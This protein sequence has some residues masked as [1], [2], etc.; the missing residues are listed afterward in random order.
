MKKL[1]PKICILL[2]FIEVIARLLSPVEWYGEIESLAKDNPV[3]YI[4]IGSSRVG[5]SINPSLF[6]QTVGSGDNQGITVNLAKGYTTLVE[7]LFGILRIADATPGKLKGTVVFLEAPQGDIAVGNWQDGWLHQE[8][9]E[10]LATTMR[11]HDLGAFWL[12]SNADVTSKLMVTSSMLSA[13]PKLK[14]RWRTVFSGDNFLPKNSSKLAKGP[15]WLA[16]EV[17]TDDD[18]IKNARNLALADADRRID[19][20]RPLSADFWDKSVLKSLNAQVT[21]AGGRLVLFRMP[22]SSI[23]ARIGSTEVGRKNDELVCNALASNGI[24]ILEPNMM[25]TDADF[26]DLWHLRGSRNAEYTQRVAQAYLDMK[27]N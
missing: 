18:G 24:P 16:A 13:I 17:R 15:L 22:I 20:L 9:P 5:C 8:Y 27:R 11:T 2:M 7:H 6:S 10:L 21:S 23:Q 19:N 4:F 1:I 25:T 14:G 26:P 3:K 12:K